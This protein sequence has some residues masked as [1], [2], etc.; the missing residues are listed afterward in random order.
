MSYTLAFSKTALKDIDRHKKS[1]DRGTLKKLDIIFN[2]LIIHPKTGVG[3]PEELKHDLS[4]LYSRKINKKHRLIYSIKE[5]IETVYILSAYA[6]YG[7][8]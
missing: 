4:G 6:H 3:Q 8:N 7:D 2:E 1:G 5:E